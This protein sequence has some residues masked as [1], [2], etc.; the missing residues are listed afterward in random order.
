MTEAWKSNKSTSRLP[1]PSAIMTNWIVLLVCLW[2]PPLSAAQQQAPPPAPESRP[3]P[4]AQ[5]S[6][7]KP[8]KI[9]DVVLSGSVRG[10]MED[11]GWFETPGGENDYTFGALT[12]RLALS[13]T[14]KR[15]DWQIEGIFPFLFH[16]P[17]DAVLPPPQGQLGLGASYFAAS[18]RQDGSASVRQAF[19]RFKSIFGDAASSLRLGRFEFAEGAEVAPADATLAALKRDRI[20]QR[21]V[22]PFGFS[23]IGRGFDGVQYVRSTKRNNLTLVA[24]RPTEGVFQLRSLK[25]IDVD[26]YYGA[27]TRQLPGKPARGEW[28]AF[29]LHYHDGR[30]ALKTDNRPQA[31]RAADTRNLRLTT[32]GGHAI[33]AFDAGR[34]T[35][36]LLFWGAAQFGRWGAL[37]HRAGAFAVE[38]GYQFNARG[39]PWLRAGYFRSTG[40]GD[41][42]DG[43]HTTF[44]QVLPTPRIYARFPFYNLMNNQDV[45]GEFR[46]KPVARLAIRADVRH[47]RLSNRRDLWYAGGGAFENRTFGYA[48]RPSSGQSELGTLFDVGFD[49]ELARRT[50]MTFYV[51]G[52]RGGGVPAAIYPAGAPRP[53]ARFIYVEL[54]Q[55]F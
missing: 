40:D 25:E 12:L 37:D 7:P 23:H 20:A 38:A 50:A 18:G 9:G 33:G 21:L 8:I 26:F 14:K 22:G 27:F 51:G 48:G 11:W 31:A 29:V 6:G 42:A 13:Q 5:P 32:I 41:P 19:V 30:R 2:F 4:A 10:R 34:G 55:R 16:L 44:F 46:W 3:A 1:F 45:F 54:L 43:D 47:L 49:V 17:T 15:V 52:I 24:V 28:R 35:V 53:P 39:T 36:D